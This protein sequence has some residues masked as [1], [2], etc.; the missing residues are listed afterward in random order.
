MSTL[1]WEV[2]PYDQGQMVE[3]AEC[4][5]HGPAAAGWRRVQSPGEVPEYFR[6]VPLPG[7]GFRHQWYRIEEHAVPEPLRVRHGR[8]E[9]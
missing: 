7:L 4:Y 1:R 5:P 6:G 9:T 3:V 8:I 2:A